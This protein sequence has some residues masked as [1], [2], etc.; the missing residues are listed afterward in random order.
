LSEKVANQTAGVLKRWIV[1]LLNDVLDLIIALRAND[2]WFL[3]N[4]AVAV[5]LGIRNSED[6]EGERPGKLE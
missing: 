5:T 2:A 3:L 6:F 1:A 4:L